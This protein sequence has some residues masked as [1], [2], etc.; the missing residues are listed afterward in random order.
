MSDIIAAPSVR[1][2]ARKKGIDLEKLSRDLGRETI[3]REDVLQTAKP[4]EV[5]AQPSY[6]DVDHSQFGPVSE[7]AMSR[8]AQVSADNLAAAN[9]MIPQVTHHDRADVSSIEAFRGELKPEAM[10]RGVKLTALAFHVKALARALCDFP[11]FNA[12]LTSDGKRLVLKGYVHIGI[13][14][15]TEHGLIV[16]VIRECGSQGLVEDCIG[17]HGSGRTG[18]GAQDQTRRDGRGF[19]DDYQSRRYWRNGFHADCKPT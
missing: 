18:T 14:V 5:V 2:L 4:A 10:A 8:F 15:D 13:A 3:A 1:T 17:D 7:Q 16:P 19:D 9:R 6:W 11:R 12:S